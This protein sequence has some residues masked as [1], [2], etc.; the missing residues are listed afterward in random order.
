M[1]LSGRVNIRYGLTVIA[2]SFILFGAA[3][4]VAGIQ[5]TMAGGPAR[6]AP[7]PT[8]APPPLAPPPI[9]PQPANN[10]PYAGASVP[11]R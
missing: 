7:V 6:Y 4:I 11:T 1:M 2:G 10:D 8:I 9:G 3:S 5:S